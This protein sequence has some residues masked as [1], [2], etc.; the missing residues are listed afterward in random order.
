ME[1]TTLSSQ[2]GAGFRPAPTRLRSLFGWKAALLLGLAAVCVVA[3]FFVFRPLTTTPQQPTIPAEHA[4]S[5]ASHTSPEEQAHW[6]SIARELASEGKLT[7]YPA[8]SSPEALQ[9]K[10]APPMTL[11]ERIRHYEDVVKNI[12]N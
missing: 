7:L 11:E 3:F 6:D 12:I 5:R 2:H 10:P 4:L 9:A 8:D 1:E